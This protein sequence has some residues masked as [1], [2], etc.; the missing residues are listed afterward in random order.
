MANL[1]GLEFEKPIIELERKIQELK[2]FTTKQDIDI[3]GEVK[4]LEEKLSQIKKDIYENLT[5]WQRVQIARHPQRPYTLDYI[6]MMMTNFLEL[7][8]DRHFA[9]D[10]AI[11]CGIA[12]LDGERIVVIGHQKGRDT[13]E[14]LER[15]FG[16]AQPEGYRKALRVMNLAAKFGIPIIVFIDTPGAYPGI[17]AE[18]RG[19]A[20]AIAYNLREMAALKTA[21]IVIVVGEGG[22]GGALAIGVGDRIYVLENA[23]YSVISPEGCA[24]I[25]WKERLKSPEAARALKLTAKDLFEMHIIDGI[26]KE[27]IGGSHRNPHETAENIKTTIKK[28]LAFFANMP[29]E[30]LLET[31]YAK[32]RSIGVFK[33]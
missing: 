9:D 6:D 28:D 4:R 31:R 33:E 7:H 30:K 1:A 20:Q 5:P 22:S 13:K 27:P 18:E 32:F 24:A 19:Q 11:V 17:G 21:I 8:G 10:K 3:S 25:L 2:G 15:N 12:E 14:N 23:Y 16:C 29:K 26:I